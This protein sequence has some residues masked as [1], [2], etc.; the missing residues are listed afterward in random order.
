MFFMVCISF[1][2]DFFSSDSFWLD[3]VVFV[4]IALKYPQ[5]GLLLFENISE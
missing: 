5:F 4:Y 2:K 1:E 3:F